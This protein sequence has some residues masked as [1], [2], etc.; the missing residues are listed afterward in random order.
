MA[1]SPQPR[2][3]PPRTTHQDGKLD[4]PDPETT[5]DAE[6]CVDSEL[7]CAGW[8]SDTDRRQCRGQGACGVTFDANVN[9][10]Q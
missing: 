6:L 9:P 8:H 7:R 4:S 3:P 10:D 1:E 5:L 2:C